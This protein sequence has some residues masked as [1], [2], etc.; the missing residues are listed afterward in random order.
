MGNGSW[1]ND[2]L[3]SLTLPE[4]ATSGARIVLDGTT[5]AELVYNAAG[6]LIASIAATAGADALGNTYPAGI[7]ATAGVIS[8]SLFLLY[9]GTPTHGNLVASISAAAG[10][11][12]FGNAYLA[13]ITVYD[14]T[15]SA[16]V[17]ISTTYATEGLYLTGS[18]AFASHIISLVRNAGGAPT[19]SFN[20]DGTIPSL[21]FGDCN[22][23][24]LDTGEGPGS[25]GTSAIIGVSNG[26][27]EAYGALA[28]VV[29]LSSNTLVLG[30]LVSNDATGTNNLVHMAKY[31]GITITAGVGTLAH[32]C[33]FTPV[34][35]ILTS[36]SAGGT[37][38]VSQVT[39]TTLGATNVTIQAYGHTGT[40]LTGTVNLAAI[41][42]G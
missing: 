1:S 20:G 16:Y 25:T 33:G 21:I 28:E 6:A 22:S 19:I 24:T 17:Q 9:N 8:Q 34:G 42:F 38:A 3:N 14:A 29:Q 27:E 15:G 2:Q 40:A 36:F 5:D 39:Y 37:P 26:V 35:A 30:N 23:I 31:T 11:D 13:G 7:S 4:G 18:G 32:G 10:I 12:A 41:F